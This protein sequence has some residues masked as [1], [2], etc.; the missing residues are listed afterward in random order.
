MSAE[1]LAAA[2]LRASLQGALAVAAVWALC[3]LVPRL[4]AALRCALWWLV[5]LKLLVA[6]AAPAAVPLPLLPAAVAPAV[7]VAESG[8]P[9]QTELPADRLIADAP[10]L[11]RFSWT[12][13]LVALWGAG[14]LAHV[15][16]GAVQFR[17]LRARVRGATPVADAA[18][19]VPFTQLEH[20]VGLRRPV[21]V[22]ASDAIE[23][24]QVVGPLRPRI[25]LPA[26]ALARLSP[27]ELA[28]TLCHELLHVRR[29]DLW[30]G[31]VPAAAQRLFFFHPLARLAAREYALAREAAC[32]AAVLRVLRPSPD[33]YGR[34]LVRLGVTVEVPRFAAAGAAPS[35]RTLK[36]RLE[37]LQQAIAGKRFHRGWWALLAPAAL[38][39]LIPF[40]MVAEEQAAPAPAAPAVA[41][42]EATAP[43]LAP[44]A[45]DGGDGEPALA[46]AAPT[47]AAA[48]TA[49]VLAAAPVA[50]RERSGYAYA[51]GDDGEAYVV[52]FGD[53]D[54]TMSGSTD[55]LERARRLLGPRGRGV[56]FE[57]GDK[58]YVVDDEALVR[59]IEALFAP[60][61]ELGARQGKLGAQQGQLGQRQGALGA[62]QGVLAAQQAALAAQ[63]ANLAAQQAQLGVARLARGKD[64]AEELDRKSREL[65]REMREFGRQM[66]DF[67]RPMAELGRQQA[68]LGREQAELGRHQAELG[69]QQ[70]ALAQEVKQ[71]LRELFDRALAS[72]VAQ[73][74]D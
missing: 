41:A 42:A 18:L 11:P 16:R 37:M 15:V 8:P 12:L 23:T 57:R 6:L 10:A 58:E 43:A 52:L 2:L 9:V 68:E 31:W 4:P 63:Q 44:A 19:P 47:A 55:D 24:P 28:L 50:P 22:L 33:R 46:P 67:G 32:D 64:D 26:R 39:V 70:A 27:E 1:L 69:R 53:G 51:F 61:M 56:W 49:P 71:Q 30:L 38:V 13:L 73:P 60:Q 35:F 3:R 20:L 48:P 66:E 5:C 65:D 54:A 34:L 40:R 59:Q 14:V 25:L 45:P 36:R 62:Q 74:L 7:L 17:R 72:G 29:G 21:V